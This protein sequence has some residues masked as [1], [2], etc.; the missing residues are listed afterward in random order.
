MACFQNHLLVIPC[1]VRKREV[2]HLRWPLSGFPPAPPS[3][4]GPSRGQ[5]PCFF[6]HNIILVCM[7]RNPVQGPPSASS[8]QSV[9]WK[10]SQQSL[11]NFNKGFWELPAAKHLAWNWVHSPHVGT[12]PPSPSSPLLVNEGNPTQVPSARTGGSLWSP[13]PSPSAAHPALCTS[14]SMSR[15]V[16][17]G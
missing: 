5:V 11:L 6:V 13:D 12:I 10:C 17:G 15:Q 7:K 8:K 2:V 9:V 16:K 4:C 14:A 1:S 3:T